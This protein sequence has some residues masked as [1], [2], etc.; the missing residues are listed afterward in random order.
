MAAAEN[1]ENLKRSIT[2]QDQREIIKWGATQG[3]N[4]PLKFIV[5]LNQQMD[6]TEFLERNVLKWVRMFKE[7]RTETSEGRGGAHIVH[8][9]HEERVAENQAPNG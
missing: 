9:A 1:I 7:G 2:E 4:P 5:E 3:G 6:G 8:S